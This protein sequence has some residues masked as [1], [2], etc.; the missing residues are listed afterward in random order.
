MREGLEGPYARILWLRAPRLGLDRHTG[1][2]AG[3]ICG[4]GDAGALA[5]GSTRALESRPLEGSIGSIS[6]FVQSCNVES[7]TARRRTTER[8]APRRPS[9]PSLGGKY[10]AQ[11]R[12][13]PHRASDRGLCPPPF[14][15]SIFYGHCLLA[16]PQADHLTP[17]NSSCLH[18]FHLSPKMRAAPSQQKASY[19]GRRSASILQDSR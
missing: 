18:V 9:Q 2:V 3:R 4:T 19:G 13:T 7:Y 10:L 12:R 1:C 5:R 8:A 11:P 17:P 16:W 6:V 14:D 15:A